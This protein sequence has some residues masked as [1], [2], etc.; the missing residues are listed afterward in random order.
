MIGGLKYRAQDSGKFKIHFATDPRLLL[1]LL[2]FC[3]KNVVR[4]IV[5]IISMIPI[6]GIVSNFIIPTAYIVYC[7]HIFKNTVP[8]VYKEVSVVLFVFFAFLASCVLYPENAKYILI[9]KIFGIIFFCLRYFI[10]GLIIL[11]DKK[12][13]EYFGK[14]H[15]VR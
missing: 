15:C 9:Q 10:V 14:H 11:P 6:I 8:C 5:L 2:A 4:Y 3:E 13:L 1:V 7:W 12:T